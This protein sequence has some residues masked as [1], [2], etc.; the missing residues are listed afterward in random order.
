MFASVIGLVLVIGSTVCVLAA[1]KIFN[2]V[3]FCIHSPQQPLQNY[4]L[5]AS[6]EAGTTSDRKGD[7][8]AWALISGSS[9]GIGFG[10]AQYLLS[11]GFGVIILARE[12]IL[13]AEAKL[14]NAYPDGHI[15]A[16]SFDC[17]TASVNDIEG[18]VKTIENL[19][20]TILINNVGSVPMGHPQFRQFCEYEA[21]GIDDHWRLNAHF[22]SHITL[23][24]LPVL[25]KNASP[26]SL[27]LN[28]TSGARI[29]LPY[30]MGYSA[31]KG[32]VTS[33]SHTLTREC[34]TFGYPIDCL[35]I[36]PGDVLSDGNHV[37]LMAGSPRA[38]EYAKLVLRR[39]DIAVKR[40]Y[41]EMS[42]YWKHALQ[43]EATNWTPE[44]LLGPEMLKVCKTKKDAYAK[45]YTSRQ[46]EL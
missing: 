25:T 41:L 10:Y 24:M 46:K 42:P 37:G 38:G 21:Q 36:V 13:E 33:F 27:I 14:R 22:M 45:E 6:G 28:V 19:P 43:I 3:T 9:E 23:L 20:V 5:T 30:L 2:F 26:R 15:K 39:V 8:V 4:R 40:G 35:L 17:M 7:K 12:R 32:Y 11:L 29:G 34:K 44:S 18:L 16:I 1:V 31:T